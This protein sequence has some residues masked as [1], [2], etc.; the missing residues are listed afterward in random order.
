MVFTTRDSLSSVLVAAVIVVALAPLRVATQGLS[1]AS[2]P[3]ELKATKAA[4]PPLID[5]RVDDVPWQAAPAAGDFVQFEPRRGDRASVRTEARVLYDAAHLYVAFRVWDAEPL[6]AQLTQR[7][8]NLFSDDSVGISLD[9]FFDRRTGYFFVTN[10]LGTQWDGRIADD[11]RQTDSTW[12]APWRVAVRRLVDGW[13]AEF[14]IPFSSIKFAAGK[15]RTWGINFAQTRRRS[16]EFASWASCS[17][18]CPGGRR[19]RPW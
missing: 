3:H 11:G 7:D 18:M 1:P 10:P 14:D 9:S 8:A 2:T 16:L 6:T 15:G 12:D 4:V 13:S 5:G 17:G 19:W